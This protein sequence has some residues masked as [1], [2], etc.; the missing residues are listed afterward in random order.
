[1]VGGQFW[2]S[3]N[4]IEI[5]RVGNSKRLLLGVRAKTRDP[6]R[7]R[8]GFKCSN[9]GQ[10]LT[11]SPACPRSEASLVRGFVLCR[12]IEVRLCEEE[13]EVQS[14]RWWLQSPRHAA[15]KWRVWS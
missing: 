15:I 2:F 11:C 12:P 8:T 13:L 1:V 14:G 7:T 6:D 5:H 3:A 9:T 10:T 4:G